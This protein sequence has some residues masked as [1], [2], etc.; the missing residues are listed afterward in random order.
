MV[1]NNSFIQMYASS[2][3][4]WLFCAWNNT[5][6][7]LR[8]LGA[9]HVLMNCNCVCLM[10]F[11]LN[12]LFSLLMITITMF[13]LAGTNNKNVLRAQDSNLTIAFMFLYISVIS[14]LQSVIK[15]SNVYR[16]NG[17]ETSKMLIKAINICK[18]M[19]FTCTCV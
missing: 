10:S 12:F 2:Y 17:K 7:Q 19:I 16:C 5:V 9:K 6:N 11:V 8:F 4:V 13:K 18:T 14:E 1:Y 15:Y 3:S